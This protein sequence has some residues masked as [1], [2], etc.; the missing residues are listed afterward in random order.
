MPLRVNHESEVSSADVYLREICR[1][2]S[3]VREET[4]DLEKGMFQFGGDPVGI[5]GLES[6][7]QIVRWESIIDHFWMAG[8]RGGWVYSMSELQTR[9]FVQQ[10][11]GLWSAIG[12][13]PTG[14]LWVFVRR[15]CVGSFILQQL[16]RP[17]GLSSWLVVWRE[18]CWCCGIMPGFFLEGLFREHWL[19]LDNQQGGVQKTKAG[20][21]EA[22]EGLR[23]SS[24]LRLDLRWEGNLEPSPR[25]ISRGSW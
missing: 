4:V 19:A 8:Q 6:W 13:F 12:I 5:S 16:D 9:E 1:E 18:V 3:P 7:R 24:F 22:G 2:E 10:I 21:A 20:G 15:L 11:R 23:S 25:R 17:N 14:D